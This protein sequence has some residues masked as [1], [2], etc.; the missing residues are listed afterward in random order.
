MLYF[1]LVRVFLRAMTIERSIKMAIQSL[2]DAEFQKEVVHSKKTV[3]IDFWAEWCGPCRAL[4]PK[5]EQLAEQVQDIEVF[6]I[7]I[8]ENPEVASQYGV[9]GIPT[10]LFF[11]QG[12]LKDK[13]VGN[14]SL[15]KLKQFVQITKDSK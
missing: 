13:L 14:H 9:R 15:D 3:L 6:K 10:L 8:D 4:A 5:I 2:T 12:E 7:N 11:D 1:G